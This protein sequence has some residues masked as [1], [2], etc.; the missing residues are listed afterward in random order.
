MAVPREPATPAASARQPGPVAPERFAVLQA[1]LAFLLERCGEENSASVPA[2]D[3]RERFHLTD[4]DLDEHLDLLNLVNFGGGCY[5]VYCAH[6]GDNVLID[7][8]LYGDSFRRAARLSPLEAKALLRALDVISPLVAGRGNSSLDTVREK[9]EAAFGAYPLRDTPAPHEVGE[10]TALGALIE[11]VRD[12]R[13]VRIS[14][15][16]RS[17]GEYSKRVVEPHQIHRDEPG[18]YLEAWDRSRRAH[19][20]FR[21]E[22]IRDAELLKES[23][24]PRPELAD[25]PRGLD[26]ELGV[27]LVHFT[28]RSAEL[29]LERPTSVSPTKQ[30]GALVQLPYGSLEWLVAKLLS[31]RGEAELLAPRH[32]RELVRE[33]AQALAGELRRPA[34]AR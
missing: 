31:H 24:R 19:R 12:R 13:L 33:R 25:P 34:R 20:T 11:G 28:G 6:E 5:A 4:A 21:V 26:R 30:G 23:F 3:L 27:A 18:W 15:L 7:K 29:E 8:E 9:I 14:Y 16:S 10:E 2:A 32:L 22:Y 1:L 17:S